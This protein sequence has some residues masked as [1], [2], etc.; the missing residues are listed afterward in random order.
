MS[1][2]DAEVPVGP[3]DL[4]SVRNRQ[5]WLAA[6]V[7]YGVGDTVTT[8]WGLSVGGVA[9]AGPIAA[10]IIEAY[11]RAALLPIKAIVFGGFYVAWRALRSPGRVAVPL[12]LAAVG[13][14]VT[15]WNVVVIAGA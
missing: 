10:P 11:G 1:D 3:L 15:T 9:E 2:D 6:I 5:V 7:L 12:A 4:L 8:F 14:V 13:G